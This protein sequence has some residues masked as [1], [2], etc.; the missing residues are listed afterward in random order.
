[1]Y[2]VYT[3]MPTGRCIPAGQL[4]R[5]GGLRNTTEARGPNAHDQ[6]TGSTTF[7]ATKPRERPCVGNIV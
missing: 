3:G 7:E 5:K 2:Y 6:A 4:T 1:M